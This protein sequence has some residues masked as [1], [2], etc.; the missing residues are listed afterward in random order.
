[1]LGVKT[2]ALPLTI[3]LALFVSLTAAVQFVDVGKANPHFFD[4]ISAPPT[5]YLSSPINK[6]YNGLV[7]LNFSIL[8]SEGWYPNLQKLSSVS[9]YVDDILYEKIYV[10]SSLYDPFLFSVYL[11]DVS[12]G[13]HSVRVVAVYAGWLRDNISGKITYPLESTSVT[14]CFS[15]DTQAP[16][17]SVTS[18]ENKTYSTSDLHLNF[19]VSELFSNASYVL[20]GQKNVAIS[21]NTT[22]T[23]LPYGEHN[24]TVY[25]TDEV[26]NTG[27][28]ETTY[29]TI[30]EPF[31]TSL[32]MA[33]SVTV[34]AVVIGVGLLVYLIKRK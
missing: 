28:S 3:I 16:I 8:D 1:M 30:E 20:D 10:D 13:N 25:A 29:F 7:L 22:L 11:E 34:A 12:D 23:N 9:Y 26:G 4:E 15:L 14:A 17:I 18:I 33:S 2:K 24:A 5:I 6:T 31:P 21:G 27:A 19:T 32:V